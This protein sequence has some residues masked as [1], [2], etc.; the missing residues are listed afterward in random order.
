VAGED[1]ISSSALPRR[2]RLTVLSGPSGVGKGRVVAEIGRTHPAVWISVSITTRAAR[3]RET[4][5][6][7]YHFVSDA[8]FDRMIAE[9]KLLEWAQYTTARYGTPREPVERMLATGM[10]VL[11][12]I[13][14]EGARQVSSLMPDAVLVFLRPPSWR[15]LTARLSGRGTESS[16]AIARRLERARAELDAEGEFDV[17]IVNYAGKVSA[18]AHQ[19]LDLITVAEVSLPGSHVAV[20]RSAE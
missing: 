11:L 1:P 19:L 13:D 5:G 3:A 10:P 12:E 20:G 2:A 7:H 14:L 4:E 18:A 15:D 8:E 6:V 17:T 16:A 9:D